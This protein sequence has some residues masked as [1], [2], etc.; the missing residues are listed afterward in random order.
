MAVCHTFIHGTGDMIQA[1]QYYVNRIVKTMLW[2]KGGFKIYVA[3]DQGI[4]EYLKEAYSAGGCQAFDWDYMASVFEHPFEVVLCDRVPEAKDAPKAMGG[5]L[6]G[7]RIGFDAGRA[8][9]A[10]S[11]R[12]ST[13]RAYTARRSSGS[14]RPIPTP[15]TTMTASSPP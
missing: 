13:V 9:T 10:R 8:P 11:P 3:G 12:S 4:Y 7:C 1:D 15:I 5:H 14:P 2:M 6:E